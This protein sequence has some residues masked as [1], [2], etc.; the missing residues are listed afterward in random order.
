LCHVFKKL[1]AKILDP[2]TMGSL[3]RMWQWL[4]CCS[5]KNSLPRILW[6]HDT[7]F[8]ASNGGTKI[9]WS[10][11]HPLDVPYWK[12]LENF[13]GICVK[14]SKAWR[15]HGKRLC[16]RRGIRVLHWVHTRFH[17][18]KVKGMGWQRK[19][20]H[21]WWSAWRRWAA[22]IHDCRSSG[23]GTFLC[24]TKCGIDDHMVQVDI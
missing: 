14:Q 20:Y 22:T 16:T 12:V 19:L 6:H 9:M 10:S 23:H 17:N 5:N 18:H 15:K 4:W 3:R 13:E 8:S 2:T 7:S 11:P 21:D 24:A 1:C